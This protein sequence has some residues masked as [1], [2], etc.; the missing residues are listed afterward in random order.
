MT[1]VV[2]QPD[3]IS[4]AAADVSGIGAA[5]Q[6]AKDAAAGSTTAVQTAAADEVSA[7]IAK[8]FSTY[9]QDHQAAVAQ[10]AALHDQFAQLLAAAGNAYTQA[11]AAGAAALAPPAHTLTTALNATSVPG[12]V[13]TLV[14]GGSGDPLPASSFIQAIQNL[15]LQITPGLKDTM[16]QGVTYPANFYPFTGFNSMRLVDSVALGVQAMNTALQPYIA[17]NTPV[18]F[19]GY[20]QSA[21]VASLEMAK[22]AVTNPNLPIQFEFIG[23]LMAPN[24]GIFERF[25][26]LQL[27]SLGI[28]FYGAT[29]SNAFP[30]TIYTLEYDGWADFPRYPLNILS[31]LNVL[32]GSIHLD[33]PSLTAGQIASAVQLPT[34]GPTQTTYYMI[35]TNQLPL[36]NPLRSVPFIGNPLADLIQP[37]MTALVNLGYGDPNYGWST[38]PA[39]VPTPIG[40]FPS[41]SDFAKL[42]PL[43]VS[44]TQQGI[45]N[46]VSDITSQ[47]GFGGLPSLGSLVPAVTGS[48]PATTGAPYS[49]PAFSPAT[50]MSA[51]AAAP[52]NLTG[53]ISTAGTTAYQA[54]VA[55]GDIAYAAAFS[56]PAYDWSLFVNNLGNP[57]NAMGLPIAA[58]TGL[59][60]LLGDWEYTILYNA[61]DEIVGA[62]TGTL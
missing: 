46:F 25:V 31:D 47:I 39:N 1:Y 24:G 18:G 4:A 34:S 6:Q 2:I 51:L 15:Y 32:M 33:Y 37:D 38:A 16:T 52:A 10:A 30:T 41:P 49:P 22:L 55:S 42:P 26:G 29:P 13:T 28:D 23:D 43:L 36:L 62:F 9:A 48:S 45:N 5:I 11:E 58:S 54:L 35:P 27:P 12:I 50:A 59:Y 20:S 53:A 57:I 44:G 60:L 8:L 17:G 56:V 3:L 61:A 14:M 19:F 21:I 40:L 7:A